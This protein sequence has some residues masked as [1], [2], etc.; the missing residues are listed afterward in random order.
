MTTTS[1]GTL[2]SI[3]KWVETHGEVKALDRMMV[4]CLSA[5]F[6]ER[7]ADLNDVTPETTVS[8][9]CLTSVR[10]AASKVVGKPCPH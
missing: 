4:F 10:G 5:L 3:V 2:H 8:D 7:I 6:K 9:E 1:T